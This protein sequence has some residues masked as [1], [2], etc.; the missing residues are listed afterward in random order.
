M[1]RTGI[2]DGA[3]LAVA[4]SDMSLALGLRVPLKLW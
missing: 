4:D 3:M 2:G 1:S